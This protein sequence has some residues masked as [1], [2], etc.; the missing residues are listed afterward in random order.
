MQRG[1]ECGASSAEVQTLVRGMAL[2]SS[3]GPGKTT[4]GY[5]NSRA[6]PRWGRD[7]AT[8]PPLATMVATASYLNADVRR[9][10]RM[11]RGMTN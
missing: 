3:R 9:R 2:A 1:G 8:S 4:T 11:L 5:E 10:A 6:A 7:A